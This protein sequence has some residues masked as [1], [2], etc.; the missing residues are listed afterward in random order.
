MWEIFS[1]RHTFLKLKCDPNVHECHYAMFGYILIMK[2]MY[3]YP[4]P[5][6]TLGT[7]IPPPPLTSPTRESIAYAC[8]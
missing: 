8:T 1:L 7:P 5:V 6:M 3:M 2:M 4:F